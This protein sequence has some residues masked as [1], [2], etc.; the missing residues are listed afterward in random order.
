MR[1]QAFVIKIEPWD[2]GASFTP[3]LRPKRPE[4]L[5][6][7]DPYE[8]WRIPPERESLKPVGFYIAYSYILFRK[9]A[10]PHD[11]LFAFF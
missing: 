6:V 10:G 11:P 9:G 4:Y 3:A 5:R 2:E 1:N 8:F 7:R